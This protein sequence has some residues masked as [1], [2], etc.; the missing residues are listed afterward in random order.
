MARRFLRVFDPWGFLGFERP[1]PV[2]GRG[3][4]VR[5]VP[6][7]EEKARQPPPAPSSQSPAASKQARRQ[8]RATSRRDVASSTKTGKSSEA[9]TSRGRGTALP[10]S[11]RSVSGTEGAKTQRSQPPNRISFEINNHQP[12]HPLMFVLSVPGT[13]RARAQRTQQ[14]ELT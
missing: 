7:V 8:C 1:I 5:Q 4:L 11:V 3:T 2:R 12:P 6:P 10:K 13:F 9:S 14:S